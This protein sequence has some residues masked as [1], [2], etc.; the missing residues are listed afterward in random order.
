[1][2][3]SKA[4]KN[5]AEKS[6]KAQCTAYFGHVCPHT[7]DCP[8]Q[9]IVFHEEWQRTQQRICERPTHSGTVWRLPSNSWLPYSI[10]VFHDKWGRT[11]QENLQKAN[12]L[13]HSLAPALKWNRIRPSAFHRQAPLSP[14]LCTHIEYRILHIAY[15]IEHNSSYIL[16]KTPASSTTSR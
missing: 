3:N 12:A 13:R 16:H 1:M 10:V 5:T 15:S 8:T 4:F 11:Q 2:T 7:V 14:L 9:L 6:A